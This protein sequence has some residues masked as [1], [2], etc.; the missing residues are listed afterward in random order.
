MYIYLY[1]V[2]FKTGPE[3]NGYIQQRY[4]KLIKVIVCVCFTCSQKLFV[5]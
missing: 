2:S 5:V 1:K 3:I 4:I